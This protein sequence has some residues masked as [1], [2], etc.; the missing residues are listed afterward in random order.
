MKKFNY[1]NFLTIALLVSFVFAFS[2]C[3]KDSNEEPE[4]VSKTGLL[5]SEGWMFKSAV[6]TFPAPF[7]TQDIFAQM[8]E[9]EKDN[10][11]TFKTDKTVIEDEG[12]TK[13]DPSDPQTLPGG[14]WA[15][16]NGETE[17][18]LDGETFTITSLTSSE[19]LIEYSEYDSTFQADI[20]AKYGFKHP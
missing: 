12:A 4:S 6:V 16:T 17:L 15:F 14:T 3:E 20:T 10:I 11:I 18:V 1:L 7:G 5:T 13:C 19:L 2:S 8:D 9:C